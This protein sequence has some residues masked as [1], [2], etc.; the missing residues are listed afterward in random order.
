MLLLPENERPWGSPAESFRVT[1]EDV[2]EDSTLSQL[3]LTP[4]STADVSCF[5]RVALPSISSAARSLLAIRSVDC[6]RRTAI[7]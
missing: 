4:N 5:A 2:P 6:C 7:G 3:W 1:H